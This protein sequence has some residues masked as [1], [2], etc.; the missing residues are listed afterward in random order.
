MTWR[1]ARAHYVWVPFLL[2]PATL[3]AVVGSDYAKFVAVSG[4]VFALYAMS[5]G[6]VFGSA[7]MPSLSQV[8]FAGI[9]AWIVGGITLRTGLP[10]LVS[11]LAAGVAVAAL[12]ALVS[13]PA[14]RVRGV[15]LAVVTL[16]VAQAATVVVFNGG[17]P[18]S[19][20]NI[21]EPPTFARS[22]TGYFVFAAAVLLVVS[23]ALSVVLRT[24][25][26]MS[27]L[28]IRSSERSAA[29]LGLAV[30]LAKVT[31]FA[32]SGFI[33]GIGGG[34]L[35]GQLGQVSAVNFEPLAS[36]TIF[37]VAVLVGAQYLDGA[38]VAG[39]S[40][41]VLPELLRAVGFPTELVPVF[42]ALGAVA[43]LRNGA[44]GAHGQLR[45]RRMAR[46]ARLAEAD[47]VVAARRDSARDDSA[48]D[49]S[50]RHGASARSEPSLTDNGHRT[51]P[52]DEGA[53]APALPAIPS[54]DGAAPALAVVGLSVR[55][56]QVVALDDVGLTVD[57]GT[58]HALV[59]PNGAG[60]STMI[61]AVSG[62]VPQ[63]TGTVVLA[64]TPVDHLPPHRRA[65]AGL[66]RTFQQDRTI[67]EL[68]VRDHVRLAARRRL[69]DREIA[70]VLRTLGGPAPDRLVGALPLV[71]RRLVEVA[72]CL[73]ARPQVALLDEPA[74]GLPAEE[75]AHLGERL[76]EAPQHWG[77][78]I[79]LVEHDMDVVTRAASVV[80]VLNHGVVIAHGPPQDVLIE[81][82]VV[83]AYLGTPVAT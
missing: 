5:V 2:V 54:R 75:S 32:A 61:N 49:D 53:P 25:V 67:S 44:H 72:G 79:L 73:A 3:V 31:A 13:L 52:A 26:G 51:R 7:G 74:A 6:V 43:V 81:S 38:I 45:D 40:V 76:A 9:A 47:R 35:V 83:A 14:L 4:V 65:R 18:G 80:T 22:A 58:I 37:A 78:A 27:W 68:T 48:R 59:G 39:A 17:F 46:I 20:T 15:Y 63:Y 55:F 64:G 24:R 70:D 1:E 29:A 21:V 34:L 42:F 28:A 23:I 12:A 71:E 56:D 33:A 60:K 62:F 69:A 19:P 36:L 11:V 8:A 66:R 77:T 41:A 50:A 82:S 16:G 30:P 57:S 10:F